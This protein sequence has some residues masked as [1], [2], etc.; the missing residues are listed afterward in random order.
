MFTVAVSR[1]DQKEVQTIKCD[2][3]VMDDTFLQCRG[4]G[5]DENLSLFINI[6]V[7]REFLSCDERAQ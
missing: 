2:S 7:V 3:W 6:S 5:G 1:T 4:I